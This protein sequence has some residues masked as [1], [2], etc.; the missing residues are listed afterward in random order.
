MKI[1]GVE[2]RRIAMP[3]VAPFRT[4]F[5]TETS[6][7][8]LL[9]RVVTPDAEGWG[10]CVAMSGPL[11]SS[12]YVDGAAEVI[13]RFLLPRLPRT[14]DAQDV[15]RALEPIKGH[16]MA[17]AAV[18][19][20]VLDAQLRAAGQSFGRFPVADGAVAAAGRVR[21]DGGVGEDARDL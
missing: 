5:G 19:T 4:S 18:E 1:T 16:R 21:V 12:E 11:Y 14:L 15:G 13:R 17:K 8:I 10:E 3:L 6:R 2:L 9:V 7:D 20:A